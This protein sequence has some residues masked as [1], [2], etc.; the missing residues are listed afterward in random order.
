[1]GGRMRHFSTV[2]LSLLL[3]GCPGDDS[4]AGDTNP[5]TATDMP[6]T[7]MTPDESE[8]TED[9][10]TTTDPEDT[11]TGSTSSASDPSTGPDPG[12]SSSSGSTGGGL[13]TVS[14]V[15][16]RVVPFGNQDDGIGDLYVGLLAECMQGADTVGDGDAIIGADFSRD[17]A[18]VEYT[19]TD[20]PDGTHYIVAFL[21]D[22]QNTDPDD[23]DPDRGD[24]ATA[25]GFG[26]GCVEVTVA[27][28]ADVTA[29][30]NVELNIVVPF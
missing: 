6:T 13:G 15:V 16:V 12:T 5:G 3:V 9:P 30:A 22:D 27:G 18:E 25:D 19:I 1:M 21:D 10:G 23:P 28:G 26:P 8:T 4:S 17:G 20:V 29:P 7:S 11:T 24:M 14:G 2:G